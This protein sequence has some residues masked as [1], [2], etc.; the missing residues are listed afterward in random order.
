MQALIIGFGQDAKLLA[1]ALKKKGIDFRILVRPSTE[2]ETFIPSF[3]DKSY[4]LYG[5]ASDINSL[6]EVFRKNTYTHVFNVA[7]NTFSQ[8]SNNNFYQYLDSNTKIFTNILSIAENVNNLWVYHPLSSEILSGNI[9]KSF[10]KPRNA[11]GVSKAT[12]LHIAEVASSNGFR[13]FYPILFNH[14]SCFRSKKFFSAK[15][16][17][18]LIENNESLLEIWNTD[19]SRDW[20]SASQY[21]GIILSSALKYKIGFTHLGTSRILSVADFINYAL[22]YLNIKYKQSK[23]NKGLRY[24]KLDDGREIIEKD[25]DFSDENR[26]IVADKKIFNSTF[27]N[28]KLIAGK[29]LVHLLFKEYEL[30]KKNEFFKLLN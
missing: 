19:S 3:I 10:I 14:E 21:M 4:L 7:G 8:S 13:L 22:E 24:W 28:H 20:G 30:L 9:K 1:I 29:K 15:L 26:V 6:L 12:E 25:K 27:G 5:D 2:L 23:N 11:Y 17:N 18:F 16:I